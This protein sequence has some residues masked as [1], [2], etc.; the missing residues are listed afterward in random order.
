MA[1][2]AGSLVKYPARVAFAWYVGLIALGGVLLA[3]PICGAPDRPDISFLEATFTATS[4]TCVTGLAVRSTGHDFSWLGQVVILSLI[5]LGGVGIMTVTTLITLRL[6]GKESLRH[7]AVLT[8]TLGAH[9]EPNIRWVLSHVFLFTI[10]FEGAGFVLLA[11]RNLFEF[12]PAT[13]LWHALFHSVSAFCNAGFGLHDDSLVRYQGDPL[14]NFVIAGLVVCGGLGFPVMIDIRRKWSRDWRQSWDRLHLHTKFMLLGTATLLAFGTV[15]FLVLEWDDTLADQPLGTKLLIAAFHSAS[16]RTAGFNTVDMGALTNASLFISIL[17]MAIGAG[18]C[19]TAGGIKVSTLAALVARAWATFH[20]RQRVDA[21]RRT[22]PEGVFSRATTTSLLFG[23]MVICGLTT[24]LVFEQSKGGHSGAQGSFLDA[25]FE[26]VS[27]LGTVGLTV[28]LTTSLTGAGKLVIMV[29][30]FCGRLG[31][32]SVFIALSRG[33]R[34][35]PIEY[36][37]DEPLIG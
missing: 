4:A 18:P 2:L 28:G 7:R 12:P 15:A 16:C 5:Q 10:V 8:E 6:G 35:R 33:E 3:L 37:S 13:A 23:L 9:A 22:I 30:M 24:L 14:V 17:L 25:L 32:I 26:V 27:A 19:S 1:K 21:F 11:I 31:P 36:P 34:E 29:L 20:G